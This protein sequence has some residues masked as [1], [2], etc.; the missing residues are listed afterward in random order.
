MKKNVSAL[1]LASLFVLPQVTRGQFANAVLS[2]ERGTGF[3]ANFTN[4][5]AALG[6]PASATSV[7]PYSPPFSTSQLNPALTGSDFAGLNLT[8]VRSLYNGSAGGGGFDLAWAR[9]V[10]G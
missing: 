6:A 9:D 2:Y 7:T 5:T 8:G 1:A 4:A 10:N 3:A